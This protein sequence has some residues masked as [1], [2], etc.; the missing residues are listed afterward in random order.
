MAGQLGY[1][2]GGEGEVVGSSSRIHLGKAER[3][4]VARGRGREEL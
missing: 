4:L 1:T 3:R 2:T